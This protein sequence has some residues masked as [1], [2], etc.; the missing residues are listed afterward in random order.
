CQQGRP[1][2][3]RKDGLPSH[4]RDAAVSLAAV[5]H[6]VFRPAFEHLL[7]LGHELIGERSVDQTGVGAQRQVA[8]GADGDSVVV[9]ARSLG[10]GADAE[11]RNLRLIDYWRTDKAAETA[12]IGNGERAALHF[13]GLELA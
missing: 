13:V 9:D 6:Y 5:L 12:E 1:P 2:G 8:D 3:L 10:H 11:N 7:H 4:E